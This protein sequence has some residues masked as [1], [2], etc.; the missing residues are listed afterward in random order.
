MSQRCV[1]PALCLPRERASSAP[2]LAPP[3]PRSL[4]SRSQ[5]AALVHDRLIR[6]VDNFHELESLH[7]QM[8]GSLSTP[9]WQANLEAVMSSLHASM[10]LLDTLLDE[11]KV[12]ARAPP[13]SSART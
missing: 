2:L 9:Q 10:E 12:R 5:Q 6:V 11:H 3:G 1:C 7:E 13:S 4:V 8:V